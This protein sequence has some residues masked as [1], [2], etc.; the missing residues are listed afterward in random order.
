MN[1]FEK[2]INEHGSAVIQEKHIKLLQE[3]FSI[4]KEK[5][6][7]LESQN[8]I[9]ESDNTKL[10]KEKDALQKENKQLKDEIDQIQKEQR[11][12]PMDK[13]P[14]CGHQQGKLIEIKPH[15]ICGDLGIKVRYYKCEN[16]EK[17]Y[18]KEQKQ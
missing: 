11:N 15:E 1:I 13:C 16:C 7:T 14:F 9:L 6:S 12:N 17:N 18:D 3:Q 2:L 4:L 5:I 10:T 8:K